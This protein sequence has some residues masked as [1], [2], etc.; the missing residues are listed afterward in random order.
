MLEV[1]ILTNSYKQNESF[2]EDASQSAAK[3]IN[4]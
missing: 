2:V 3:N 1:E 4:F